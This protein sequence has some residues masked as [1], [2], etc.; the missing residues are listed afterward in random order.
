MSVEHIEGVKCYD[1]G[2]ERQGWR[3]SSVGSVGMQL[4]VGEPDC[5]GNV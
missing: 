3:N 2:I 1:K 4:N 5:E